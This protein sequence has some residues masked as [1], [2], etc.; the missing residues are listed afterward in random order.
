MEMEIDREKYKRIYRNHGPE[1]A[2]VA[3]SRDTFVRGGVEVHETPGKNGL[4]YYAEIKTM[5]SVAEV[6]GCFKYKARI[7]GV[8]TTR[9]AALS[10]LLFSLLYPR[11]R[12][13]VNFRSHPDLKESIVITGQ[14]GFCQPVRIKQEC[15][16]TMTQIGSGMLRVCA[17]SCR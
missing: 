10:R 7:A 16:R 6:K 12:A 1:A 5:M 11:R 17:A 2:F 15:A 14:D 8:G 4:V 13:L 3:L 9:Q